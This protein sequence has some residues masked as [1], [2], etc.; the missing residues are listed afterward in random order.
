VALYV[1][2]LSVVASAFGNAPAY[3]ISGSSRATQYIDAARNPGDLV[4]LL[5]RSAYAYAIETNAPVTLVAD[6]RSEFG[7]RLR[8][9]D[10]VFEYEGGPLP[11]NLAD[12]LR[13][14]DRVFVLLGVSSRGAVQRSAQ[15]IYAL[16]GVGFVPG[17]RR[18]FDDVTVTTWTRK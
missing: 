8:F 9:G 5:P 10:V 18:Q 17:E 13:R 4:V 2:A 11:S 14:A 7:S 16:A 15:V 3:P 12:R 1:V 6:R